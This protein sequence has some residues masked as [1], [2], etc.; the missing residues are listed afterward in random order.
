MKT[1]IA[2]FRG[3]NLGGK[4]KLPMDELKA[5]LEKRGCCDVQTYIQS[6]NLNLISDAARLA[7]ELRTAV[8][9]SHG[10]KPGVLVLI[11]SELENA[12]VANH[13]SLRSI[14]PSIEADGAG[15]CART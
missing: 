1:W 13:L 12:A 15:W 11:R 3:I 8:S 14:P 4:T 2:L 6:G 9:K 7:L 5:V 10:F